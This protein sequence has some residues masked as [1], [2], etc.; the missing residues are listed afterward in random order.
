MNERRTLRAIA[1]DIRKYWGNVYFGAEPYLQAMSEMNSI[2]DSFAFNSGR[3]IVK[4]F[5]SN[6]SMFRGEHARRIKKELNEM[7]DV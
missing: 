1:H 4:C 6:A 5:L 3:T 7:L 2:D